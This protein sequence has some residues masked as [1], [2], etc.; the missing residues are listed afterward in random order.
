NDFALAWVKSFGKGRIFYT[1]LGHRMEIYWN[2]MMLKF[3]LDGI[4]FA[5]GDLKVPTAP[6]AT[7]K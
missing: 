3:Y 5:C 1:A 6:R 2:P 4:Q 7:G